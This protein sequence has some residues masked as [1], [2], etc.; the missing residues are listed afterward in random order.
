MKS[1]ELLT[2]FYLMVKFLEGYELMQ[3]KI[4]LQINF[5]TM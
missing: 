3:Q 5:K 4:L 1:F 2:E